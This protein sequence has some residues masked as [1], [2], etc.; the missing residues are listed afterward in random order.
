MHQNPARSDVI[1]LKQILNF[2]PRSLLNQTARKTSFFAEQ[3]G[4]CDAAEVR[5][6]AVEKVTPINEA[7]RTGTLYRFL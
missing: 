4:E 5:A 7:R 3:G 2:I 6:Q 1:V